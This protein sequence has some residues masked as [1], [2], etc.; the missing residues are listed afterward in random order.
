MPKKSKEQELKEFLRK[1]DYWKRTLEKMFKE[2][3]ANGEFL[4]PDDAMRRLNAILL[5]AGKKQN[6]T[7]I[8]EGKQVDPIAYWRD[9]H[10]HA[11]N[12]HYRTYYPRKGAPRLSDEH[13]NKLLD[14]HEKEGLSYKDIAMKLELNLKT[15]EEIETAEDKYRKRIQTARKRRSI[16]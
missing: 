15:S 8:L 14:M 13:L 11:V 4:W 16:S 9:L 6:V 2:A 10:I 12:L 7:A 1:Y 5:E 3:E